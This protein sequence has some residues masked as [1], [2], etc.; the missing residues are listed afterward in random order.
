MAAKKPPEKQ[1][2]RLPPKKQPKKAAPA[3]GAAGHRWQPYEADHPGQK[4]GD[5][6][7]DP[8]GPK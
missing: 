2:V 1:P 5:L 6:N 7:P 4:R 3:E 8:F